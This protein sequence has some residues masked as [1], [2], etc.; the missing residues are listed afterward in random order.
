MSLPRF[1]PQSASP[2]LAPDLASL[3]DC[4]TLVQTF[5][6][7]VREDALLAPVF[8]ARISDDAWPTHLER[9][10]AFWA[11]VLFAAPLYRG[12]PAESHRELPI[13]RHHFDR[14]L[15]LWS[16]TIDALFAGPVATEAKQRAQRM[17]RV[18]G[19]R[20]QQR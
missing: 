14:W 6:A 16:D 19:E 11:T 12:N 13:A 1:A 8:V 20:V 4:R 2:D 9:M 3:S 17:A 5:Y 18:L 10:A 15:T 7:R